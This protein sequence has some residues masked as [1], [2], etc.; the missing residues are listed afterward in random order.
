VE[1][2]ILSPNAAQRPALGSDP[3]FSMFWHLKQFAYSF[4][5]TIMKRALNEA[6]HGNVMPLGVFAWYIPT[7]IAADVTKG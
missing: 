6:K 7:M 1:G 3:H 2:A 5:E 4:H